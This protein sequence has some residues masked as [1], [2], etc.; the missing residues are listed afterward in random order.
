MVAELD[1]VTVGQIQRPFGLKGEVKVRSLTDVPGRWES[2]TNVNLVGRHGQSLETAVTHVRR[3]NDGV[4]V[5]LAAFTTPEEAAQWRGGLIQAARGSAPPPPGTYY[6]CDLVGLSVHTEDGK[7]IGRLEEVWELPANHVFVVRQ[8]GKEILIPAAKDLVVA[9][10]LAQ[11]RMTV[12]MI[13]GL[14]A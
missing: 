9:V 8:D 12:R 2:L 1:T 3:T 13:E 4:I 7:A 14:D 11:R 5:G 6:E 10:D